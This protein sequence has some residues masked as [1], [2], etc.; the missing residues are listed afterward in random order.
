MAVGIDWM[1]SAPLTSCP[2]GFRLSSVASGRCTPRMGFHCVWCAFGSPLL[3]CLDQNDIRPNH[4]TY[5][6]HLVDP[7]N[8]AEC[9]FTC[10]W[11]ARNNS[12]NNNY[13][14]MAHISNSVQQ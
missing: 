11:Y 12:S 6:A 3:T 2:G 14:V 7:S 13:V 9:E 4:R 5:C 1:P 8:L 10:T